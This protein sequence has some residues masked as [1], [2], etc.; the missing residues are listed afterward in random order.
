MF[1]DLPLRATCFGSARQ[2]AQLPRRFQLQAPGNLKSEIELKAGLVL[3]QNFPATGT[4]GRGQGDL[5]NFRADIC[6]PGALAKAELNALRSPGEP[7]SARGRETEAGGRV[8]GDT[9]RLGAGCS[10]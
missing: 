4:R 7:A 10:R 8:H 2:E 6:N 9:E 1:A 5:L 3:T